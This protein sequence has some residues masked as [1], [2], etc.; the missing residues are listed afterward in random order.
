MAAGKE[1]TPGDMK[2]VERLKQYWERGAGAAKI[3][4]GQPGDFGRCVRQLVDKTDMTK[5]Q[6]E[7][8]CYE[9]H[10]G[11]LGYSPQKHAEMEKKR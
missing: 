8:Y 2:A 3:R 5:D 6:A 10:V 7:G 11:A 9:R 4:W 1:A